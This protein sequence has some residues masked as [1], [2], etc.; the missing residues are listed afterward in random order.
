MNVDAVEEGM[1][2]L[3]SVMF[4]GQVVSVGVGSN[5]TVNL[6]VVGWEGEEGECCVRINKDT[7]IVVEPNVR[8]GREGTNRPFGP[9]RLVPSLAAAAGVEPVYTGG[10]QD[11]GEGSRGRGSRGS[12][13][14]DLFTAC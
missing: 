5:V 8:D 1:L 9:V 4:T 13:E 3:Y 6:G 10:G 2:Q 14:R 7:E 11:M 12:V